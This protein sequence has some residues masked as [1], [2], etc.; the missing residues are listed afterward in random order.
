LNADSFNLTTPE[1][2]H[3]MLKRIGR[4]TF[5][6]V[7]AVLLL[8]SL[9]ILVLWCR[10][11]LATDAV[12]WLRVL[13]RNHMRHIRAVVRGVQEPAFAASADEFSA[14]HKFIPATKTVASIN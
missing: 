11:N 13:I 4:S 10:S 6:G 3:P 7:V 5:N 14:A 9:A 12:L 2:N 1:C 8:L